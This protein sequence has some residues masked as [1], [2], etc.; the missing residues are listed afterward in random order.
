VGLSRVGQV[1]GVS[2]ATLPAHQAGDVIIAF[3]FRD[4]STTQPTLPTGWTS[5]GTRSGTSCC[6]RAAWKRCTGSSE[7]SG[8]WTNASSVLFI[9]FRGAVASGTPV[10]GYTSQAGTTASVTYPAVTMTASDGTSW[11]IGTAGHRSID[12]SLE[13][14]PTGMTNVISV[15]DAT[16][17]AAGHDT[18]GGVSSWSAQ[19]VSVGG[20]AS[21]WVAFSVELLAR[22]QYS[23]TYD[24]NGAD[25]GAVPVD[26]NLYYSDDT[27]TVLGNPGGL[28]KAGYTFGGWSPTAS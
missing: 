7:T 18:E 14:A 9:V 8:T 23:V 21:G 1:S 11:I 5:I 27:V 6:G 17:E 15:V 16:D 10:G 22:P 12:T 13:T 4:G 26:S 19:S 24:A 20:T 3:A 2:S 25:S 28:T